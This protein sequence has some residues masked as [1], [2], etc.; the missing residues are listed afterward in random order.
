MCLY[1]FIRFTD[2]FLTG[3]SI[4]SRGFALAAVVALLCFDVDNFPLLPAVPSA[5]DVA[6]AERAPLDLCLVAWSPLLSLSLPSEGTGGDRS[7]EGAAGFSLSPELIEDMIVPNF[8]TMPC[9]P[10]YLKE[11]SR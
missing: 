1:V 7:L 6:G 10:Q 4:G 2:N 8:K 5:T 11:A 9:R 3:A